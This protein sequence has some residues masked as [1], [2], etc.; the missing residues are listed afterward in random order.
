MYEKI[1][2]NIKDL[3]ASAKLFEKLNGNVD[4]MLLR[5][6]NSWTE[7]EITNLKN[8]PWLLQGISEK[9]IDSHSNKYKSLVLRVVSLR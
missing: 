6:E 8:N 7:D 3:P 2:S 4:G 1:K 9:T 5:E